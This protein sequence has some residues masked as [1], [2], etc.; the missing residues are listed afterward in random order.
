MARRDDEIVDQVA[1]AIEEG[2]A[3]NRR[4]E[5]F[6]ITLLAILFFS[7]MSLLILGALL[8]RWE[9]L[10]PGSIVQIITIWPLRQIAKLREDKTRLRI[11]LQLMKLSTSKESKALAAQLAKRLIEQV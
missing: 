3:K 2:N 8:P 7:G 5:R 11:V 9:L 10:V 6:E 1:K 4:Q